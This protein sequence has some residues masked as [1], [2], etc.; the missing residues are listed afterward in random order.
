MSM[1]DREFRP[2]EENTTLPVAASTAAVR[3]DRH[4]DLCRKG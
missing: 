2:G 1:M 4:S 3:S